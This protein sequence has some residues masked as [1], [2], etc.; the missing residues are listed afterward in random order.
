MMPARLIRPTVGLIPTSPF[1]EDGQTIEPS[2][3]VPMPAAA[4]FAEMAAPVPGT[5]AARVSVER[6]RILG[7]SAAAAPAAGGVAGADIRPL[8][9]V[10]LPRMTAPAA[11]N[12]CATKESFGTFAPTSA[13]EPA[14]VIM[15]SRG[16]D[17]VFNEHRDAV[18]W[19][20]QLSYFAFLIEPVGDGKSVRIHF[21]DAVEDRAAIVG[22]HVEV[23]NPRP[24][25]F[26]QKRALNLPDLMPSCSSADRDFVEF[27]WLGFV[28]G[29]LCGCC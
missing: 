29:F 21:D 23:G 28:S 25:F 16:C 9:Q 2:V 27:G 3:S 17:V 14:V 19:S 6:V 18:H 15:R 13:S 8:A 5:R 1:D 4:R 24:I 12:F 7:Q 10:G 20:T 22:A 26:D 11:R